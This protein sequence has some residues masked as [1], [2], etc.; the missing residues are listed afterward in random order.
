[1]AIMFASFRRALAALLLLAI[2]SLANTSRAQENGA[3]DDRLAEIF[4][5]AQAAQQQ[6]DYA[7]AARCYEQIVK[8][9]PD[10]PEAWANLGLMYQFKHEYPQ[11]N[12]AFQTA[13]SKNP[14]L[15]VPNLFLGLN[16][17]DQPPVALRYLKLAE[18]LNPK[19][20]QAAMGLARAY[21]A[22]HDHQQA[23]K[24]FSEAGE[25]NPG[26][27]E[28]WYGVA[29]NYLSLQDEAVIALGKLGPD[30]PQ[31]RTLVA[32]AFVIQDRT[33][34]AINIY[35]KFLDAPGHPPCMVASLGFAY[36]EQGTDLAAQTFEDAVSREPGCLTARLGLARLAMQKPD[37]A[38]AFQ[39]LQTAWQ[40]DP[41]FLSANIQLA[42][43]KVPPETL[44]EMSSWLKQNESSTGELG[45]ILQHAIEMDQSSADSAVPGSYAPPK[46]PPGAPEKRTA[47][48]LWDAGHYSAC[49]QQLQHQTAHTPA[50]LILL[51][52]CAYYSGDYL[53]ALQASEAT[54]KASP[55]SLPAL[56]WKAKSSQNLATEALEKMGR[57]APG[58]PRVHFLLAELHRVREEF[59]AAESEYAQAIQAQ[60]NDPAA[61]LGLAQ[62]Y[63]GESQDDKARQELKVV[64]QDDSSSPQA[65]FLMG[66]VLV[67]AHR[68]PDAIPYL[69]AALKG[70]PLITPEAHS[71]LARCYLTKGDL[72]ASL[73]ELKS[74]L[75]ADKNGIYHY[76]LYQLYQRLGDSKN[77]A[78]ALQESQRLRRADA[79]APST[80]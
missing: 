6:G 74:A 50:H 52:Q 32:D 9:R 21:Q 28:A 24:W 76:Q 65:N 16:Q 33:K 22:V 56:Y 13:L 59:N 54:L 53:S 79:T 26:D 77:A 1:M 15:Y 23:A 35:K 63:Y 68:F 60:P 30:Q 29:T 64:L 78:L 43:R 46:T 58:S 10:V 45:Q 44:G 40:A 8:L 7:T 80:N 3:T 34:D 49:V 38:A 69:Q 42:W 57:A 70:S 47:E 31:A 19:D 71:L 66:Q 55:Q 48:A 2:L 25:I 61:H 14:K 72:T 4:S 62:T 12:R 51:G 37:F 36:L 18:H 67:R 5:Q 20:E 73:D 75:P 17:L 41:N 27:P 11:A 39:Q